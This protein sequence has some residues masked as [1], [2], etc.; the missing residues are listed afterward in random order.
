MPKL[1]IDANM[2]LVFIVGSI[3]PNLLGVAKRV[4]EYRP[5]DF[6][7]LS[8]YLGCFTEIILLPNT[9]SEV[10]NLLDHLKGDRRQDCMVFLAGLASTGSE[11]YIASSIAALQ[12]EYMALGMTDSAILCALEKDTYL[13]T[14]DN[15]LYLAAIC[16]SQEAQHFGDLRD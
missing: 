1:I 9:V 4:K 6:D 3:N 16:R 8:T 7:V 15:E 5:S 14:A 2:L 13:L 10:S 12:P 11:K